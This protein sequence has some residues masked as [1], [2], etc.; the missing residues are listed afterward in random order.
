MFPLVRSGNPEI[1]DLLDCPNKVGIMSL[2]STGE[3][4]QL[5]LRLCVCYRLAKLYMGS[6]D[7]YL[8]VG[9]CWLAVNNVPVYITYA[10]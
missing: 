9:T 10:S 2:K 4:L 7:D 3:L 8:A 5:A 1:G 6:T